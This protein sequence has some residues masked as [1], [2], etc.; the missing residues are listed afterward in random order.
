LACAP[1]LARPSDGLT[2]PSLRAPSRSGHKALAFFAAASASWRRAAADDGGGGEGGGGEGGEDDGG[3]DWLIFGD[4]D[5]YF[6]APPLL[7]WLSGLDPS[8]AQAR[9][10]HHVFVARRVLPAG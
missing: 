4:D 7:A 3:V 6:H 2:A 5:N 8:V 10:R 9:V 1:S